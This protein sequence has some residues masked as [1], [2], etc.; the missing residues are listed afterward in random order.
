M[1]NVAVQFTTFADANECLK[2]NKQ[3]LPEIG[4]YICCE[5]STNGFFRKLL[6]QNKM[7]ELQSQQMTNGM[8]W[9]NGMP[10]GMANGMSN[11]MPNC[12]ANGMSNGM[13]Y[14]N[15]SNYN[16]DMNR[17]AG[18]PMPSAMQTNFGP[19]TAPYMQN[20]P[21]QSTSPRNG[22]M[23]PSGQQIN[24]FTGQPVE[25]PSANLAMA[26]ANIKPSAPAPA[27]TSS[28]NPDD[29][30]P[31]RVIGSSSLLPNGIGNTEIQRHFKPLKVIAVKLE[32]DNTVKIAF[33]THGDAV[34]AMLK[35]GA[36]L[37]EYPLYL[38][39]DS[40]DPANK[41]TVGSWSLA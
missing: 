16:Y 20:P 21:M 29:P 7:T 8:Q 3:T 6:L 30:Y 23:P 36:N 15:V 25:P 39:L 28:K 19:R 14:N 13:G 10:N 5:A 33:K 24:M 32:E 2:R 22:M 1:S 35:N 40:V 12:M 38:K 34:S 18:G 27:T 4:R 41:L 37:N 17:G 31:H 26:P 9:Q 11:G